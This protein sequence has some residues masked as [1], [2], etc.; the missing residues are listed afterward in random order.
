MTADQLYDR[1]VAADPYRYRV[2]ERQ[3]ELRRWA[4]V[5]ARRYW[6][7][8]ELIVGAQQQ[9][10]GELRTRGQAIT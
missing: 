10:A 8:E 3:H 1:A 9:L 2:P 5:E 7:R 4:M 6:E